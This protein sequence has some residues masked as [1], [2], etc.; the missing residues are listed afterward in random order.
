MK[1]FSRGG[2][3]DFQIMQMVEATENYLKGR[4][5]SFSAREA[6]RFALVLK[7]FILKREDIDVIIDDKTKMMLMGIS[8]EDRVGYGF[9][10]EAFSFQID[11]NHDPDGTYIECLVFIASAEDKEQSRDLQRLWHMAAP[12]LVM[13]PFISI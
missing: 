4:G 3:A 9:S 8:D 2:S 11:I 10:H 12:D 7:S 1:R 5:I 6:A 13:I